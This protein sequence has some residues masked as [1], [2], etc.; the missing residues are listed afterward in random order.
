MASIKKHHRPECASTGTCACPFRLDYRPQGMS[1]PHRRLNFPTKKAAE[2]H[3]HATAVKVSRGEY[4]PPAK[5]PTFEA[6]AAQWLT[7]KSDR[8]PATQLEARNILRHLTPLNPRR[9]DQIN[10][11]VIEKLRDDLVAA[12]VLAPRSV[13]RIMGSLAAIF[14]T[15]MRK[16][17]T[18]MNPAAVALRPRNPVREMED[19]AKED[20]GALRPDEV[21]SSHEIARLLD[22]ADPGLW[23]TYIATAAAC[24]LRSEEMN[25]LQWG[26]IELDAGRMLVRRSLSWARD[27]SESGSIKPRFF[28]TK[29]RSGTRTLPLAPELR[30]MLKVWKIA[31]PPSKD[32][33]VFCGSDGLPLRRSRVLASGIHPACRRAGLRRCSVKTFRHSYASGLLA[34]G[35]AITTVA[36]LMG[37]SSPVITLKTYSHWLPDTDSGAAN[38]YA[39]TFLG[40]A[41]LRSAAQA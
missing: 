40:A 11:S 21:L 38:A 30:A 37:H 29:T 10:V 27:A 4:V 15:A 2:A 20:Q 5:V 39:A 31:C 35:V 7:E 33:L 32:D 24:G 41:G 25:A 13:A 6:A 22:A 16:G 17:Y 9:L 34:R 18:T 28:G 23:K 14:K 12:G 19:D 36:G 8:H 1:G 3:L 26:D